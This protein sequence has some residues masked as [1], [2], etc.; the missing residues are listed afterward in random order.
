[1]IRKLTLLGLLIGLVCLYW[2]AALHGSEEAL[3][4]AIGLMGVSGVG[5]ASLVGYDS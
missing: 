2:M 5:L 3:A 4:I 1:M